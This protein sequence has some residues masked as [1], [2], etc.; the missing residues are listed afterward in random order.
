MDNEPV[1]APPE[2]LNQ[3]A[4]FATGRDNLLLADDR[5]RVAEAISLELKLGMYEHAYQ[6]LKK[7][8]DMDH[9]KVFYQYLYQ[10]K[11]KFGERY[12]EFIDYCCEKSCDIVQPLWNI[13]QKEL[14]DKYFNR[15]KNAFGY[16][17]VDHF[18]K[19]NYE[20]IRPLWDSWQDELFDG[21]FDRL[22]NAF[23]ESFV[24][25]FFE[26]SYKVL[27]NLSNTGE[28]ELFYEYFNRLKTKFGKRF[29]SHIQN[30]N[31]LACGFKIRFPASA[32]DQHEI[33][34]EIIDNE[35]LI[36]DGKKR[37][38]IYFLRRVKVTNEVTDKFIHMQNPIPLIE[39]V[40]KLSRKSK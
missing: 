7:I 11:S 26:N 37:P 9:K 17:F 24:D 31:C 33:F 30:H 5:A 40:R 4:T 18:Y 2:P 3:K 35:D 27:E 28:E 36:S 12:D 19:K 16:K 15:L 20:I 6:N 14:F 25:C 8:F 1:D 29:I 38:N 39:V 10:Y 32:E 34:W 13:G 21:Y 23:G 22:K